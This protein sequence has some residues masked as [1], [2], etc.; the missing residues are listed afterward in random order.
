MARVMMTEVIF[1]VFRA[2]LG[3]GLSVVV[4]GT[5]FMTLAFT[6]TDML[7]TVIGT[8]L[9]THRSE[10]TGGA[11][12]GAYSGRVTSVVFRVGVDLGHVAMTSKSRFAVPLAGTVRLGAFYES[13]LGL[14]ILG[15][16]ISRFPF[17]TAH[18]FLTVSRARFVFAVVWAF[19]VALIAKVTFLTCP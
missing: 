2:S 18:A 5:S 17:N 19:L 10:E 7:V 3:A 14:A 6:I 1:T 12:M 15:T 8:G 16:Q 11:A 13:T 4:V 9:L